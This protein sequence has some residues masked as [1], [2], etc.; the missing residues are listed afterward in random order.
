MRH[1]RGFIT[2]GWLILIALIA[3]AGAVY[4]G[5]NAWDSYTTGLIDEGYQRGVKE[6]K[7][8]YVAR[9]NKKLEAAN[10]EITRL[11]D[12]ARAKEKDAEE[13][14]AAIETKRLKENADAKARYDRDV[15][16]VRSGKRKLYDPGQVARC[17]E[18]GNPSA[19]AAPAA[20][21]GER[22]GGAESGLLSADASVFLITIAAEADAI[23]G[24]LTDAQAVILQDRVT[25]NS[26]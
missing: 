21:T 2:D 24:Q 5:I 14:L 25:C 26:P 23:V 13:K 10:R 16:D 19:G 20:T 7:A 4:A 17:P 3:L 6:T 8:D 11:T 22:D 12:S 18:P 15:A 9:D 1:Q